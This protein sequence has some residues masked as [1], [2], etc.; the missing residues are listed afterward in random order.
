MIIMF[1]DGLL[2]PS[3][4][5]LF[6]IP[7]LWL[8][9]WS[10]W[11]V[12]L[13]YRMHLFLAFGMT[14]PKGKKKKHVNNG[15]SNLVV[16]EVTTSTMIGCIRGLLLSLPTLLMVLPTHMKFLLCPL[17]KLFSSLSFPLVAK[18]LIFTISNSTQSQPPPFDTLTHEIYCASSSVIAPHRQPWPTKFFSDRTSTF[19]CCVEI[20]VMPH[21]AI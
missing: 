9:E 5:K 2:F 15:G 12:K 16:Q 14:N 19:L 1:Y 11:N 3:P 10:I 7:P 8:L 4:A 6:P 21:F 18:L 13:H 20:C 17:T